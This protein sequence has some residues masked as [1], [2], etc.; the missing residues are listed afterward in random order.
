MKLIR[1]GIFETNSSSCHS[2]VISKE[3]N[4]NDVKDVK[5]IYLSF[6]TRNKNE[7]KTTKDKLSYV[8]STLFDKDNEKVK[9]LLNYFNVENVFYQYWDWR[10]EEKVTFKIISLKDGQYVFELVDKNILIGNDNYL[11]EKTILNKTVEEL[12]ELITSPHLI[13][14]TESDEEELFKN[15]FYKANLKEIKKLKENYKDKYY[16]FKTPLKV[17][18]KEK[19]RSYKRQLRNNQKIEFFK[20]LCEKGLLQNLIL[21]SHYDCQKG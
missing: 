16:S 9:Q 13:I 19:D 18:R 2:L 6:F 1:K 10:N 17:I 11:L 4:E 5:N 7:L 21:T 3:V 15:L 12:I 8:L 14:L 20:W